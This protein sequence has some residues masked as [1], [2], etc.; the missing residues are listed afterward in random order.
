MSKP[1]ADVIL[2]KNRILLLI[3]IIILTEKPLGMDTTVPMKLIISTPSAKKKKQQNNNTA[4]HI[5]AFTA[6]PFLMFVDLISISMCFGCRRNRVKKMC[7][8][9]ICFALRCD[10]VALAERIK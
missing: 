6:R 1:D 4:L 7:M 3:N 2:T 5:R 8:L 9:L 10:P